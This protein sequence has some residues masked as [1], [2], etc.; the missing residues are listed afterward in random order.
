M[1]VEDT[2]LG[3]PKEEMPNMF[4]RFYRPHIEGRPDGT[5]LGLAICQEIVKRHGGKIYIE[6]EYGKG[7][8]VT[9]EIGMTK[10]ADV[11]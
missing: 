8:K 10:P 9:V 11:A 2:G 7:T 4:Q 1:T 6:S 5:G 3:I